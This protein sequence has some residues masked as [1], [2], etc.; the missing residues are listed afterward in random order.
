MKKLLN[1][2]RLGN[3]H[4]SSLHEVFGLSQ[5][6]LEA[7]KARLFPSGN[8]D[9]EI[10][11][12]SIF[13]A[14]LAAVKE[15][16]EDLLTGIGVRKINARTVGIHVYTE[17]DFSDAS[18]SKGKDRPDGL[19]VV[20]SG[21][22][23][24]VIEW[25][26]FVEVKVGANLL[27]DS[28]VERYI[29]FAKEIGIGAVI[30]ISNQLVT[31]PFDSPVKTKKRSID[32]FHW[33]WPFL[34]VSASRL[35][36]ANAVSDEDHVFML[37][38]LCRYFEA[39]K[40]IDHFNNMGANWG[41][42]VSTIRDYEP[43]KKLDRASL[44]AIVS[45]YIQEEKDISLH[46]TDRTGWYVEM[47]PGKQAREAELADMLNSKKV[48][49]SSYCINKDKT[50][51]FYIDVD[52]TRQRVMCYTNVVI[53]TGK[54]VAQTTR[55]LKMLLADAGVADTIEISA[56]YPRCKKSELYCT[57]PNLI[58]QH[59][60]GESYSILDKTKGD[61]VRSFEVR[62]CRDLGR[63][64]AANRN[65]IV[66]LEDAADIFLTQVMKNLL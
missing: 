5:A 10:H 23:D 64:F 15:Y 61:T 30:T 34:K 27:E 32:L 8:T 40:N 20:T 51:L 58:A 65:F 57:L 49:T 36:R 56:S 18:K 9:Q 33:S 14:S 46:L 35:V 2:I 19:I 37:S 4:F 3:T 59:E 22:S 29:N 39:H 21:K 31:T 17:M 45:G 6:E 50:K 13:L 24:P 16:R 55:L 28:Q 38:E 53:E 63:D 54:A 11:T 7:R 41:E 66:K 62:I 43:A 44:D 1:K 60:A 52:F 12:T 47:L 42:A 26:A 48:V 25:C